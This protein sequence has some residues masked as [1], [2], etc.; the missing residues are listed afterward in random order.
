M[1]DFCECEQPIE[2]TRD[3]NEYYFSIPASSKLLVLMDRKRKR[4]Y[5]YA[6][7]HCPVCGAELLKMKRKRCPLCG[8][9]KTDFTA[10]GS[11]N[12]AEVFMSNRHM[13]FYGDEAEYMLDCNYCPKCGRQTNAGKSGK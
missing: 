7:N 3:G 1:C 5:V 6:I 9:R 13:F 8:S 2:E 4:E 11:N 12:K 10:S